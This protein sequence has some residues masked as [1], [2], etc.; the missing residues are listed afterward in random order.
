VAVIR[1][2]DFPEDLY[3]QIPKHVWVKLMPGGLVRVG[4]TPAGYQLLGNSLIAIS[5]KKKQ[6]G[7]LV[8]KGKSL[9]MFESLKY[10]GPLAAPVSGVLV[11]A[12]DRVLADPDLAAV[13]P[14]GEGWIAEVQPS[15]WDVEK[16]ALVTGEA[17]IQAYEK[18]LS[19]DKI[20]WE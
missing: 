13:D 15:A 9:A 12:N 4:L 5:V 8:A 14:Y 3:Y 6:I 10:I 19:N 17:G 7:Q 2:W 16:A 18:W 20:P 11:R 1:G